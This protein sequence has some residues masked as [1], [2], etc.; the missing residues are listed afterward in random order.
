MRPAPTLDRP[1]P[2][3]LTAPA[4]DGAERFRVAHLG[5]TAF[6]LLQAVLVLAIA[7]GTVIPV[8]HQVGSTEAVPWLDVSVGALL[9]TYFLAAALNHGL[10][11]TVLHRVYAAD[12]RAGR[13]R[14]RW[15]EFA[16][17]A[18]I[19]MLLIALSTGVT[20]VVSLVVIGAAT[21]VM[22]VCG[23][24]Q[25]ALN[26]PGRRTTTMVPF[27]SGAAAALVPWSIV[28][29]HLVTASGEREFGLSIFLALFILWASFELNQWLVYHQVGPWAD[30]LYGERTYLVLSL[31]AK[32]AL[33]WQIVTGT[34]LT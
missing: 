18:P 34:S 21:L 16:V 33:A 20:G 15:A 31:V 19:L 13:N 9:A 32:S 29:V 30:Y 27:W 23:W 2:P 3:S 17:S 7:G 11:A 4:S 10:S 1:T 12:L 5:L 26:P 24:M 6:H 22:T 8:T 14:I 25:E 28:A